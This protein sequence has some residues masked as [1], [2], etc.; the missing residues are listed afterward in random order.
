M[1]CHPVTLR[2][3]TTAE[4]LR[5]AMTGVGD[6]PMRSLCGHVIDAYWSG[7]P[8][9][10]TLTEY[11]ATCARHFGIVTATNEGIPQ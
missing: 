10:Q 5:D 2:D 11:V 1:D 3:L 6:Q 9:N 4:A 8:L 7:E